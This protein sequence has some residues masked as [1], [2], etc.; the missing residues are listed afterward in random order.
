M[1][2]AGPRQQQHHMA[3][4][5]RVRIIKKPPTA[6]PI[7]APRLSLTTEETA[8]TAGDDESV[9]EELPCVFVAPALFV[10]AAV[11]LEVVAAGEF[12]PDAAAPVT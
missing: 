10:A 7:M 1:T 5:R 6:M 11:A 2:A 8:S 12:A 9:V 4:D 3:N